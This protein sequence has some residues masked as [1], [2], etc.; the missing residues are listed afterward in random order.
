MLEPFKELEDEKP[1]LAYII[2]LYP[3]EFSMNTIISPKDNLSST[4]RLRMP[5]EA[6]CLWT[7]KP[8]FV[9][10]PIE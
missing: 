1:N 4:I 7:I 3:E 9:V 2:Q 5:G 6:A 10:A 8:C